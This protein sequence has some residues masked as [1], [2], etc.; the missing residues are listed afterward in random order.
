MIFQKD[1]IMFQNNWEIL[2][3]SGF[4]KIFAYMKNEKNTAPFKI[5]MKEILKQYNLVH[6]ILMS[7]NSEVRKLCEVNLDNRQYCSNLLEELGNKIDLKKFI[8][9][10]LAY[11]NILY[12]W[13]KRA[14]KYFDN[15]K[16]MTNRGSSLEENVFNIFKEEIYEKVKDDL[17]SEFENIVS[18]YRNNKEIDINIC[19]EYIKFIKLFKEDN[20]IEKF[21]SSTEKYFND[22]VQAH[23]NSTFNDFMNFFWIEIDKEKK[24]LSVVFPEEENV[25]LTRISEVIYYKNFGKLLSA[26][27]GFLFMLNNYYNNI[28]EK[29]KYTFDI[30]VSNGNSFSMMSKI[31][32]DFIKKNF[33][34]KIIIKEKLENNP[35]IVKP[36]DVLDKTTFIVSYLLFQRNILDIINYCFSNNNIMNLNFKEGLADIEGSLDNA[37]MAYVLPYFFDEELTKLNSDEERKKQIDLGLEIFN[38]VPDKDVFID[39]YCNLLSNRILSLYNKNNT[40]NQINTF[41]L[42]LEKNIIDVFAQECGN[43]LV[44]KLNNIINDYSLNENEISE[45]FVNFINE[46][47]EQKINLAEK[48][49]L[50]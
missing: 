23:I 16:K 8:S 40:V 29:L 46:P 5:Q 13:L 30:F 42:D 17:Y 19:K 18:Q 39:I 45:K 35:Q 22:L 31:F 25:A 21:M 4:N 49:K 27:D 50:S 38:S 9:K 28:K 11:S 12:A 48:D 6:E 43:E 10:W 33:K 44:Q 41:N 34:E 3:Q 1:R 14:F 20:L 37:N 2:V 26:Q 36:R 24:F 7:K 15:V 47:K 32:K